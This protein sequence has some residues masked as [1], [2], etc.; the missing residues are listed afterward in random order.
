LFAVFDILKVMKDLTLSLLFKDSKI[1][2][3]MKKRGFGIGKWNGYGGKREQNETIEEAAI[4]EIKEEGNVDVEKQDLENFGQIDF[5]FNDKPEWNQKV[6]IFKVTKWLGD[7]EE[8]EEMK[9]Q[10]FSFD[11]IP[12]G[13]MWVGDDKWMAKVVKGEKVSGKIYF[14]EE[15]KK[16][17][18]VDL[19]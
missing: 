2:L 18:L 10:W 5:Y 8:T 12:Y 9:P 13:E 16:L 6:H 7:P 17:G 14:D 1:L 3:A 19:K 4:R 11:E 15:G